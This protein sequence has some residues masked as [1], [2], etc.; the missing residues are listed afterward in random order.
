M[1]Y[2]EAI[3]FLE[4]SNWMG[5]R[6]GLARIKEL[7]HLAGDPQHKM[8]FIHIAGTNGK[9]S[10]AAMLAAVLQEA[11]YKT[12]LYTS[13][14]LRRY[15][16]RIRIDGKDVSDEEMCRAAEILEGCVEQMD[17]RPTVFER[18]TALALVCFARAGCE[19]VVLE[20]GMGGRL[21]ATNVVDE[22]ACSVLCHIDLDHTEI[23]GD[24]L[25]KIAE[26]KAGII[27]RGCPAVAQKQ[28][29]EALSVFRRTCEE[30]GSP[31][32]V[33]EP[34]LLKVKAQSLDGQT[35]DY[36]SRQD[37]FIPLIANY[38][39][40][41]VLG[42]LDTVDVLQQKG[43]HISEEALREG[44]RKT[45]WAGRFEILGKDPLMII[46]GAHNPDGAK[47]LA[48]CL[49]TYLP[50]RKI[51]FLMGVMADKDYRQMIRTMAP[52]A[53]RFV[54]VTPDSSRSLPCEELARVIEEETGL[55]AAAA[56][57]VKSGFSLARQGLAEG[58]VLCIF[59]SLYQVGDVQEALEGV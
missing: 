38:Q 31:L 24:T 6:L 30:L 29:E 35:F 1:T 11:G 19:A 7:L 53:K 17:D 56:G 4:I 42:V 48:E 43:W 12:G 8:Q 5:S 34:Q 10:T 28:S 59:G 36:R 41:N 27:K 9:G 37:L 44:L 55:P 26:E 22:P 16:E 54:A 32:T 25:E 23:L 39:L 21:D 3:D 14:H 49:A 58:D 2:Q 33:T 20:V 13:P 52:F 45:R 40:V 50:D 18:I 51:T 47:Q 57:D 15:N 46:D